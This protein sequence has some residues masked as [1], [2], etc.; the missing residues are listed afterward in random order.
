MLRDCS[1]FSDMDYYTHTLVRNGT[2][3]YSK[4]TCP[5][6]WPIF[7][8][9]MLP[10]GKFSMKNKYDFCTLV[11]V[12]AFHSGAFPMKAQAFGQVS[13]RSARAT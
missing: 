2:T 7:I 11:R 3:W 9:S 10:T 5:C 13:E 12:H 6:I 1:Q 8:V 4:D